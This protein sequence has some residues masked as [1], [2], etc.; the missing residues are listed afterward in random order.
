MQRQK[1]LLLGLTVWGLVLFYGITV[2]TALTAREI[3]E[4]ALGS[5]VHLGLRDAEGTSWTGSGFVVHDGQ[6]ATNSSRYQ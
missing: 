5:T 6:I 3:A 4:I 2:A 1:K